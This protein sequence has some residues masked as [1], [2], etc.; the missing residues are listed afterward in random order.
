MNK[1]RKLLKWVN[2]GVKHSLSLMSFL[3]QRLF[4]IIS[5]IKSWRH[6]NFKMSKFPFAF[7]NGKFCSKRIFFV[8]F[9]CAIA[10]YCLSLSPTKP[11]ICGEAGHKY[12]DGILRPTMPFVGQ[13]KGK[14]VYG[15]YCSVTSNFATLNLHTGS[16]ATISVCVGW[17]YPCLSYIWFIM[18][19]SG[20]VYITWRG[21]AALLILV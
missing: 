19:G 2:L 16:N 8:I 5:R 18:Y 12:I 11:A 1:D 9:S 15:R 4:K 7:R 10:N 3:M 6:L 14:G 17:L 20:N 21:L 13:A